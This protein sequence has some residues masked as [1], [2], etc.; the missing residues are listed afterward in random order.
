MF[1][2]ALNL[3][4]Q[5]SFRHLRQDNF[6]YGIDMLLLLVLFL[7]HLVDDLAVRMREKIH[8]RNIFKLRLNPI[9]TETTGKGGINV[10]GFLGYLD[11]LVFAL[12]L[13]GAHVMEPVA[14]LD[15]D[16]AYV[17]G[18]GKNHLSDVF[19]LTGLRTP[20]CQTTELS[21]AL[22]NMGHRLAKQPG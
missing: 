6:S 2:A 13:K 8:E 4:G 15:Q 19:G 18:H 5:I 22:H 12:E 17:I 20:K 10:E 21:Y 7:C 1:V 11:L 9:D 16:N 3:T 14:Q